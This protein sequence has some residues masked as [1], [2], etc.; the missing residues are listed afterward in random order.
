MEFISKKELTPEKIRKME[1]FVL[2]KCSQFT[3]LQIETIKWKV[4]QGIYAD[5]NSGIQVIIKEREQEVLTNLHTMLFR[6]QPSLYIK[7][8]ARPIENN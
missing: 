4:K 7:L 2:R 1:E 8:R 5:I 6:L 3:Q